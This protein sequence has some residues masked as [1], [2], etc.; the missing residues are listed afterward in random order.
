M[1]FSL[2]FSL[3][4]AP[5]SPAGAD[6]H[7]EEPGIPHQ[8]E[9]LEFHQGLL[10]HQHV[11]LELAVERLQQPPL[12]PNL[13]QGQRQQGQRAGLGWEGQGGPVLNGF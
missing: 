11:A 3:R 2:P 5:R 8:L 7:Q 13:G 12:G 6:S 1:D 4:E 10:V 9:I